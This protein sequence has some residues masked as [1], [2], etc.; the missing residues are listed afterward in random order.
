[1]RK[2][3]KILSIFLAIILMITL[4]PVNVEAASKIKL[5][6]SKTTIYAGSSETLKVSGTRKK[7]TWSSSN[8]NVATVSSK[9]KITAKKSGKTIITAKV[10]GKSYKCAVTVKNPTLNSKKKILRVGDTYTLK[11]I[12]TKVKSYSSS[13]KSVATVNSKGKVTA[14]AVGVAYISAKGQDGKIYQC[15]FVV[16]GALHEHTWNEGEVTKE[17]TCSYDGV[18]TY[19]CT[20]CGETKTEKIEMTNLHTW[21]EGRVISEPRC[22]GT[23][24]K[25]YRCTTCGRTRVDTLEKTNEHN[26]Y[27]ER[28]TIRPTCTQDGVKTY[29]CYCGKTKTEIIPKL[30]AHTWSCGV[31]TK[32]PT[33]KENGIKTYTCLVCNITKTETISKTDTHR[34]NYGEVTTQPTCASEGIKTY[35]CT[36]CGATKT[37]A[38]SKTETHYYRDAG[39][40]TTQPTCTT[41]GVKTYTCAVCG[42]T[43]TEVVAKKA[44][45]ESDWI[46]DTA[47]DC[48]TAGTKHKECTVC[49]EILET[50]TIE[51]GRH[52]YTW[53][54]TKEPSETA[55][56][57]ENDFGVRVGTCSLCGKELTENIIR[58]DLGCGETKLMY[59]YFDDDMANEFLEIVNEFRTTQVKSEE[60]VGGEW[61]EI[62]TPAL[63]VK[64]E[65]TTGA[66]IRA[67]EASLSFSHIRP[68]AEKSW[69]DYYNAA[70]NL[71]STSQ[72]AEH[73]FDSWMRSEGHAGNIICCSYLYTGVAVFW[74]DVNGDGNISGAT[75]CQ[76][77][78]WYNKYDPNVIHG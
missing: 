55:A 65:E 69:T 53:V 61:V 15:Q 48:Q 37:E 77:F 51:A 64:D 54:I 66:K 5:N 32:A 30:G 73:A 57:S 13:K 68:N 24:E 33:C 75:W 62:E 29:T 14:K 59:G 12:G 23:G 43:K 36:V 6:K 20:S 42:K 46:V 60:L 19:T 31:V 22:N 52:S 56:E 1:M 35:T 58:I 4:V 17:P 39:V 71:N 25:I 40:I 47:A 45:T 21:D 8:K 3:T 49:H 76:G 28:I 67:V 34:W 63:I 16:N 50:G 10:S 7:I 11:L 26:Y 70:E 27:S 74:R 2:T 38:I 9:G 78:S 44:H 72:S 18:K 41:E